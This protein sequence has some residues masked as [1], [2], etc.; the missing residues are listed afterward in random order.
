LLLVCRISGGLTNI[1]P[2]TPPVFLIRPFVDDKGLHL[3]QTYLL[4]AQ[5][6]ALKVWVGEGVIEASHPPEHPSLKVGKK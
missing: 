1:T 3:V 5:D 6:F 2:Q 4:S